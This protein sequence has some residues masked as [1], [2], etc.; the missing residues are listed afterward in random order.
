MDE[1]YSGQ[2]ATC[3]RCGEAVVV[4]GLNAAQAVA[5]FVPPVAPPAPAEPETGR[6]SR[7]AKPLLVCG[8]ALTAPGLL[9]GALAALLVL[10]DVVMSWSALARILWGFWRLFTGHETE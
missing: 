9:L 1:A 7:W 6:K 2:A 8:V 10:V 3:G 4:P 5:N